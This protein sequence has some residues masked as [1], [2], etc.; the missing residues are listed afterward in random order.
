MASY[1]SL[2]ESANKNAEEWMGRHYQVWTLPQLTLVLQLGKTIALLRNILIHRWIQNQTLHK[3]E[4]LFTHL[5]SSEDSLKCTHLSNSAGV[6]GGT[7]DR[8][9]LQ[10]AVTKEQSLWLLFTTGTL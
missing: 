9:V 4:S 10:M 5:G 7:S 1:K 6:Y 3:E 8:K 2:S